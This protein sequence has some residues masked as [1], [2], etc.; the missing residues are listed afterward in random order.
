[1]EETAKEYQKLNK[2][3]SFIIVCILCA[4]IISVALNGFLIGTVLLS[5]EFDKGYNASNIA[6]A[7]HINGIKL[8]I[9]P[10]EGKGK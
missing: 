2:E 4:F 7:Y 9:D 8:P 5:G 6:W 10:K 3:K 1:M